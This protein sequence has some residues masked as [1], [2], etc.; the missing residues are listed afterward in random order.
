MPTAAALNS[1][2]G[3]TVYVAVA[4]ALVPSPTAVAMACT[5]MVPGETVNGAEYGVRLVVGTVPL[6][7]S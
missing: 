5:W 6:V 3:C 1:R 4:V 7:V 2:Y